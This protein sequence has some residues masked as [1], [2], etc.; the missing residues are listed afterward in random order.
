[1]FYITFRLINK[2]SLA[3]SLFVRFMTWVFGRD[4]SSF[5]DYDRQKRPVNIK[6]R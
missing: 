5:Q 6:Q 3:I 2:V 4:I 1:M